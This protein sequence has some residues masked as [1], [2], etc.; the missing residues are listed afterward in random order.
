MIKHGALIKKLRKERGITQSQLSADISSRGTLAALESRGINISFDLLTKYL[1]RMN[2]TLEEY[3]FLYEKSHVSDKRT[4]SKFMI[5][6]STNTSDAEEILTNL[7]I[8]YNETEDKFYY[9]TYLTNKLLFQF[10]HNQNYDYSNSEEAHIL[11]DYLD[12]VETWGRF[13][14]SILIN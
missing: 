4:S 13:E 10:L 9:F 12:H 1:D 2:I 5:S 6:D 14:L 3:L 7:Q 8:K 11:K